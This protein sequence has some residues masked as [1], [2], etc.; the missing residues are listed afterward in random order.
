MTE[1]DFISLV[2]RMREYGVAHFKFGDYEVSF[3]PDAWHPN[4]IPENFLS[5]EQMDEMREREDRS[6]FESLAFHSS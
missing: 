1:E 6:A 5:V 4:A 3:R 2:M